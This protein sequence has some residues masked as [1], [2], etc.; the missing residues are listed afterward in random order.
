[1]LL[2]RL[3]AKSSILILTLPL[4][5]MLF[6]QTRLLAAAWRWA[7]P[8]IAVVLL[9]IGAVVSLSYEV[10]T[11]SAYQEVRRDHTATTVSAGSGFQKQL[12]VNGFGLTYLTPVTKFMAHLPLAFHQGEPKS[13]LV[14]CFGMGTTF[15]S[16]LSWQVKTTAVEL[17]PSVKEAFGFYFDDTE[18]VLSDPNG[19]IVVDDG[20]RFLKR[21]QHQFDVVTIDPPPPAEAAGSSL[22]YSE[23][24]YA[25]V[26][27]RLKPAGVVQ[28][29]FAV[30]ESTTLEAVARSLSNSFSYVKAYRS[31]EGFGYHF[32]ASMSPVSTPS[33]ETFALRMPETARRDLLEWSPGGNLCRELDKVLANEVAVDQLCSGDRQIRIT[34]DRPFNE[35]YLL[36]RLMGRSGAAEIFRH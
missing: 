13:A 33:A 6:L 12:L 9:A 20:R 21:T 3:G 28:Q 32:L 30:G 4:I 34:D 23:E 25:L 1:M 26:K 31:V 10:P 2:P 36:R 15:R 18:A 17:L 19:T 22:L 8:L 29:W 5:L 27:N 16:L 14:I 7:A 35:Y 11:E 24:F